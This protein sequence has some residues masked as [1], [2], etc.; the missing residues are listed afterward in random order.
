MTRKS[1][2]WFAAAT[3]ALALIALTVAVIAVPRL[4][5]LARTATNVVKSGEVMSARILVTAYGDGSPLAML[6]LVVWQGV[7]VI[8]EPGPV[9]RASAGLFGPLAG[10]LISWV[11]AVGASTLLFAVSRAVVGGPL[12]AWRERHLATASGSRGPG[13]WVLLGLRLVPFLPQGAVSVAAGATRMSTR[14]FLRATA[15]GWLPAVIFFSAHAG[16]VPQVADSAYD[17]GLTAAAAALLAVLAWRFR[18]RLPVGALDA[19][20]RI[21]LAV[22]VG[23]VAAAVLAYLLIPGVRSWVATAADVLARGD[24]VFVRDYLRGFGAWAPVISALLMVFQ[25]VAAP[26]PAFMITFAN[27]LL[28]GWAW[29]A[30]LSWSSAMLGAAVCF[31]IAR[32]LGRP[33]VEKLVGGSSAL[34]VS[35]LFFERYGERAVLIARLLPFVSFDIISYGAGLTSMRF[36]RFWIATG[37]GQLPATLVYSYLGQNLT[38]SVRVLFLIF[39]FTAV[40]FIAAATVRPAFMRRLRERTGSPTLR[41]EEETT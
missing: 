6:A 9:M 2:P 13:S 12:S 15:L 8:A 7:L 22:G 26:L 40:V 35:D 41:A 36:R 39:L 10:A 19:H 24:V 11:G 1:S 27:G 34:E 5:Q 23:F 31:A 28:F 29:G 16:G 14:D 17:I 25:S 38:G 3:T 37:I 4:G 33:I 21:Q 30:A 20:R 18:D 32:A